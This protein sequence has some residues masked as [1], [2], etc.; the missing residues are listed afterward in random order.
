MTSLIAKFGVKLGANIKN[1][2]HLKS[3]RADTCKYDLLQKY[4]SNS[5]TQTSSNQQLEQQPSE[6]KKPTYRDLKDDN[7]SYFQAKRDLVSVLIGGWTDS[8]LKHDHEQFYL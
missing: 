6:V 8:K 1:Q 2:K 7:K 5:Q 4:I 3:F